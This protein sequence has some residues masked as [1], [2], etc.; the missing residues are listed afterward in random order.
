MNET[1]K[2]RRTVLITGGTRG[3]GHA[4]AMRLVDDGF[5]TVIANYC[6]DE[7]S[8]AETKTDLERLGATC[9]LNRANLVF[10]TEIEGMFD[11]IN[12]DCSRID[13]FVHCAALGAF[14]PLSKV[15]PNQW[16]LSM[17]INARAFLHCIQK[18]RPLMKDGSVVAIS[19]LGSHM[20]LPNYG[21]IGPSK[22]ALEAVVRQLAME[23]GSS[24]IRINA[25]AAGFIESRAISIFPHFE[26]LKSLIIKNTPA[27]RIGKPEDVADIVAFLVSRD[28]RWIQGQVIFADGGFSLGITSAE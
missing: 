4:V 5:N 22:A 8:A 3:I 13:A 10:P 27:G 11:R 16:D 19:S 15:K 25:V 7:E 28:A 24:G 2:N 14:K 21:A 6:Q 23:L 12:K 18:C 17:A 20:A 1:D 26:D 9:Y